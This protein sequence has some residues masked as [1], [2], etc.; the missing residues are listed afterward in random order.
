MTMRESSQE[1]VFIAYLK[2]FYLF[3]RRKGVNLGKRTAELRKP[4]LHTPFLY[5]TQQSICRMCLSF[6]Q[7]LG[8]NQRERGS[9]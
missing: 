3:Q 4:V 9:P 2:L 7:T 5:P 8:I 1:S 6:L